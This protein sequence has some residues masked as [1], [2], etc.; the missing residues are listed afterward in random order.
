M[1]HLLPPYRYPD[2]DTEMDTEEVELGHT[3]GYPLDSRLSA[4]H[5]E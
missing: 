4:K 3:A 5:E 1:I 2:P